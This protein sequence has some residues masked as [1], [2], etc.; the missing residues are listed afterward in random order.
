MRPQNLPSQ[1]TA[2]VG[3]SK[4]IE[5]IAASFA[6]PACRLLTLVGPGGIGKTRLAI[7]AA[8]TQ[9]ERFTDDIFFIALQ[10]LATS[11]LILPTLGEALPAQFHSGRDLKPQLLGYFREQSVLLIFDNF[12]HLLDG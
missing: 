5:A 3:R 8:R 2:F 11:D 6:N 1:P 9:S 10:P 4:E 7:E 12:E